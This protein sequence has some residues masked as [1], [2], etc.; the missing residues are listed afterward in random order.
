MRWAADSGAAGTPCDR[1]PMAVRVG[2]W[3][4][5]VDL[6]EAAM[7]VRDCLHCQDAPRTNDVDHKPFPAE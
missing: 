1:L 4:Y 6:E 2:W 7:A 3:L 5:E